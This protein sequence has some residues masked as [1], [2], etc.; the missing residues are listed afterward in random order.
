MSTE[1][2]TPPVSELLS[3]GDDEVVRKAEWP[4]YLA[5]GFGS[6][7]IPELIRMATDK[8]LLSDEASDLE[9]FAPVHAMRVLGLL[10]AEA[11]IEPLLELY[12]DEKA[13]DDDWIMEGLPEIYSRIGPASIPALKGYIA[14]SSHTIFAR[15]YASNSLVE[16]G[17]SHPEVRSEAIEAITEQV[18]T[19]AESDPELNALFIADLG[20][21]KALETL[22]L[23]EQAFKADRVDT[24]FINWDDVQVAMG[25]KE[26]E[27]PEF[28]LNDLF[29]P[30]AHRGAPIDPR[31]IE[32]IPPGHPLSSVSRF[33]V[34]SS[35]GGTASK[36]VKNKRKM[37]KMA[38]K[39][40]KR[41]K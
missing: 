29:D 8:T 24:S 18:S 28:N 27:E 30:L 2:Y 23:I 32:I 39:K 13:L 21:L 26:Y 25:L 10:K 9:F 16:V 11:A 41:R 6:E 17:K 35:P 33:A 4:D 31:S 36:K 34:A 15:G 40:N 37:A 1:T 20:H 14:D 7:H 19:F 12:D 38:R 22:P 5:L 3:Y